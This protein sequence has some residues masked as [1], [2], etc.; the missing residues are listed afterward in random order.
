MVFSSHNKL[1]IQKILNFED[2]MMT[3]S[4]MMSFWQKFWESFIL[5]N[6][7]C[8]FNCFSFLSMMMVRKNQKFTSVI[9]VSSHLFFYIT[10]LNSNKWI[11]NN[12]WLL[13]TIFTNEFQFC[14]VL[15]I[16][17]LLEFWTFCFQLIVQ[18]LPFNLVRFFTNNNFH[19][20]EASTRCWVEITR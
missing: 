17:K 14:L 7:F 6:F 10:Y 16:Y 19:I 12:V 3:S 13:N 8:I 20:F 2:V 5:T 15:F 1:K 4:L 11:Y 18:L 9:F